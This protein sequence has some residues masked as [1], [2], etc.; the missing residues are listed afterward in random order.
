MSDLTTN[1]LF[2]FLTTAQQE[3]LVLYDDSKD[4]LK[5]AGNDANNLR[6]LLDDENV[7][8]LVDWING[9]YVPVRRITS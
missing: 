6:K 5:A 2:P 3:F 9:E 1:K 7:A 8:K 4:Y